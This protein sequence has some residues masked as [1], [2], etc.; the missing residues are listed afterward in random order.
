MNPDHLNE[1]KKFELALFDLIVV[2]LYPFEETTKKK[3][4]VMND[5]IEEL[6][7]FQVTEVSKIE[8]KS[9]EKCLESIR[10]YNL[11]KKKLNQLSKEI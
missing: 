4:A 3:G 6:D 11:E 10:P 5:I 7:N 2:S 9:L 8:W 1:I